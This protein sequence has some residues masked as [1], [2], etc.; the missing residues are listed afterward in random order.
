MWLYSVYPLRNSDREL[1][2]MPSRPDR[3]P[4]LKLQLKIFRPL[5]SHLEV[6]VNPMTQVIKCLTRAKHLEFITTKWRKPVPFV[7]AVAG[8]F[9]LCCVP[10]WSWCWRTW[11]CFPPKYWRNHDVKNQGIKVQ[12][13]YYSSSTSSIAL[14]FLK[15]LVH[16]FL[17]LIL[18]W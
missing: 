1:S 6:M 13:R 8:L 4:Q 17:I 12:I 11:N 14:G 16:K 15:F 3:M 18:A 10:F 7:V 9:A 5:R 2:M